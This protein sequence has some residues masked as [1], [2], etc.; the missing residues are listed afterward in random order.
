MAP[1]IGEKGA[2]L[3]VSEKRASNCDRGL[4]CRKFS[5]H[6]FFIDIGALG[7][8]FE[9]GDY[10]ITGEGVGYNNISQ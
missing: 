6:F 5:F 7:M 9:N 4:T 2:A 10:R 3:K 8:V 1:K